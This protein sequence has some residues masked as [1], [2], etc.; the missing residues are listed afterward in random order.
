MRIDGRGE[1]IAR[2]VLF[3]SRR[4]G[5]IQSGEGRRRDWMESVGY[6]L[7]GMM[8]AA[9]L[10]LRMLQSTTHTEGGNPCGN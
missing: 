7:D 8:L 5:I 10:P 1:S 4:W 9:G 2:P 6:G 3:D